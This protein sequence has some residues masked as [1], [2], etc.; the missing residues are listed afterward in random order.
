M[1]SVLENAGISVTG[2]PKQ[3][4]CSTRLMIGLL[5]G[6]DIAAW[7]PIDEIAST[8]PRPLFIVHCHNDN[9]IQISQRCQLLTGAQ[10]TDTW[11]IQNCDIHTTDI[12][13][14]NFP[15][16]FNNHAIDYPLNPDEYNQTV[17]RFFD[18]SLE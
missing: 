14:A 12:A 13:P 16:V 10:V 8:A 11:I 18:Q 6:Y 5:Y 3:F 17:V 9:L 2:L 4:L 15:E 1:L 7:R